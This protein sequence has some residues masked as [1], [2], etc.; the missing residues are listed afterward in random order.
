MHSGTICVRDG[1]VFR[2][3]SAAGAFWT[4]ELW[5]YLQEHPAV[6]A[7]ETAAGRVILS[8]RIEQIPDIFDDP[9]YA[10]PMKAL[11]PAHAPRAMLGVPL[12]GKDRV[13]GAMVLSRQEPGPFTQREVDI[14][15]TFADQASIAIENA[16]LF[17][18]TREALE[19]QTATSDILNVIASSPTDTQP[20]F[21]AIARSAAVLCEGTNS[22][23]FCLRDGLVHLA[24]HH[25]LSPEQLAFAPKTFPAPPH[26][27][28][29]AGR[30]II[31]RAVAHVPDIAADPEYSA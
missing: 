20:V 6:P 18:E 1:E 3:R 5:R 29:M 17:N 7:R 11:A 12:L 30:A 14:L 8:R 27:G 24:G 23:V 28:Y 22:G 10:L 9:E 25:N 31:D 16:R 15:Q 4:E 2:F 21:D 13:E 26:R 19:R